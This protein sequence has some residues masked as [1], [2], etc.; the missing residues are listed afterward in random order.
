MPTITTTPMQ[1]ALLVRYNDLQGK[2]AAEEEN[3]PD[4]REN[5]AFY[6]ALTDEEQSDLTFLCNILGSL[7]GASL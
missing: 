4:S 5:E 2:V 7:G 6:L 1:T 3:L